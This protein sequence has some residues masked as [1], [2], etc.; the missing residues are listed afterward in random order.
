MAWFCSPG[1]AAVNSQG[2]Q[3]LESGA[4]NSVAPEGRSSVGEAGT[5]A[6]P[7]FGMGDVSSPGAHARAGPAG[8]PE[9]GRQ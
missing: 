1:G 8:T 6:P 3:P 4:S 5:T 7:G 9:G 2:R